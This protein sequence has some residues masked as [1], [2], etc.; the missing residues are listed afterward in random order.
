MRSTNQVVDLD[1]VVKRGR[2]IYIDGKLKTTVWLVEEVEKA[3]V[4]SAVKGEVLKAREGA[5]EIY[6][7]NEGQTFWDVAKDLKVS[8]ELLKQQNAEIVEP[9]VKNE[10]IVF[11]DQYQ[12][13]IE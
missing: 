9:F 3:V 8:Q 6:F 4:S 13:E 5:L 2:E 12:I 11:F 7:A 10:K 1:A